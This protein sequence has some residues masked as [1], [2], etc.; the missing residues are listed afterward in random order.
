PLDDQG[1]VRPLGEL[2]TELELLTTE[3]ELVARDIVRQ[4]SDEEQGWAQALREE[5]VLQVFDPEVLP[6][7][8]DRLENRPRHG[9]QRALAKRRPG[10]RQGKPASGPRAGLVGIEMKMN[11]KRPRFE[12]ERH[13]LLG[14]R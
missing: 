5:D 4:V 14:A 7:Q 13:A 1:R 10:G 12:R 8:A 9:A 6:R 3:V 2:E 11:G